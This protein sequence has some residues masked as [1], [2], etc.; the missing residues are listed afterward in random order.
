LLALDYALKPV[1]SALGAQHILRG[2]FAVDQQ[3]P[4][5]DG[6]LLDGAIAERLSTTVDQ[7]SQWLHEREVIRQWP[8]A[9]ARPGLARATLAA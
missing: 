2:V 5:E 4:K 7:L 1:L 3:V 9:N 8:A 6:A